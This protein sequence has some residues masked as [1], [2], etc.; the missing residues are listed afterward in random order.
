MALTKDTPRPWELG[1]FEAYPL[2]AGA[3]VFEGSAVG[4]NGAGAVRALQAGDVFRGFA[5]NSYS[6]ANGD[7]NARVRWRGV[8][9]LPVTGLSATSVG[10]LVYASD[11]GT[12][13][14]TSSGNSLIGRIIRLSSN[15]GFALVRITPSGLG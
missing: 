1:D 10:A 15:T 5:D 8:A 9:K 7:V 14:L 3:T 11:D 13:N 4:D 6:V 2:A 12:F